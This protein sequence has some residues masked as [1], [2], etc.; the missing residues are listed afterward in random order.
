MKPF[1]VGIAG[2]M[3]SG[4]STVAAYFAEKGAKLI[5]ADEVVND[6]YEPNHDGYL[7]IA[8]YFGAEYVSK[9]GQLNRKKLASFVFKDLKKLKILNYL[10]HPLVA[11]ETQK[12][13]DKTTENFIVL[14]A[15]YFEEK[16]LGRLVD[17]I[18]WVD[19]PAELLKERALQRPGM[20]EDLVRRI[21]KAQVKPEK[22]DYVVNNNGDLK[23][24]YQQ[25]DEIWSKVNKGRG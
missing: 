22:I 11:S 21:L 6:L 23:N 16:H 25:L 7:K 19:A 17:A 3:G 1:V 4:K 14:E 8:N 12:I 18:I 13:I 20:S 10:I 24:L 2:Y 15:V 9:N 5:D